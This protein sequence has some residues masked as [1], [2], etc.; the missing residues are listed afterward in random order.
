MDV[1]HVIVCY[2]PITGIRLLALDLVEDAVPAGAGTGPCLWTGPVDN[3]RQG[4]PN[5]NKVQCR[6]ELNYNQ[7]AYC[8]LKIK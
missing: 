4:L 3:M 2:V 8:I 5:E 7:Y 1:D 6:K